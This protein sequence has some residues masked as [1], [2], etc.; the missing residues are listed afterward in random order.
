MHHFHDVAKLVYKNDPDYIQPITQDIEEVFDPKQNP[1]FEGGDIVRWVLFDGT[2][3]AP[4]DRLVRI[5]TGRDAKDVAF[6]TIFGPPVQMTHMELT[7]N[8]EGGGAPIVGGETG[9]AEE[10][11]YLRHLRVGEMMAVEEVEEEEITEV[12][13]VEDQV[14][15]LVLCHNFCKN[16]MELLL[17]AKL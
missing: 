10:T 16:W 17:Y 6:A 13:E 5:G 7:I 11:V 14:W 3:L 12:V 8:G 2:G 4:V 1:A 9:P 15:A